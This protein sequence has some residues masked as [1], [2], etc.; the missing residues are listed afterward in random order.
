MPPTPVT[1]RSWFA[2]L[3]VVVA[4]LGALIA[5]V[6]PARTAHATDDGGF[7]A[8]M[9]EL[10]NQ[11]RA[12][13][14]VAPLQASESLR[15]AAQ[16]GRYDGCGFPVMGRADDMGARNYFSHTILGCG[17]QGLSSV[18]GAL[19]IQTSGFGE[20][21]AWMNGTTD[22]I[23]AATRLTNDLMA[24]PGHKA[25]ILNANFT[26]AGI[27]SWRTAAGKTWSGGGY[28][29]T[30]VFVGVQVFGR[31]STSTTTTPPAV[32]NVPTSLAVAGGDGVVNVSWA[33]AASGPAVDAYGAFVWDANGYTGRYAIVGP[34]GRA[35]TVTGVPNGRPYYVTLQGH[36]S[37]GWGATA[38]SSWVTV[39]A[40]PGPPTVVR[41]VPGNGSVT[42]TWKAPANTGTAIDGYGMFI[43]DDAGAYTGKYAWVCAACT[44]ATVPG[45][46][47]GRPY[48]AFIY[49]HNPNGWGAPVASDKVVAG[50]PGPPG[51]VTVARGS[52]SANVTWTPAANS[53][54]PID[55]YG[56]FVFDANGY[57]GIAAT[58][59]G[60][61]TSGTV[62]GLPSGS[63]TIAVFA[64]NAFGWGVHTMSAPV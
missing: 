30:N 22:P 33:P 8:K 31:M 52:G 59:C 23:V 4:L 57:T 61:C 50:T 40:V 36:N 54:Y 19:G 14:G 26:H 43:F 7:G 35:A 41:A 15:S 48:Y 46:V 25:N 55:M 18:L 60:T 62:S 12:G 13:A 51:T 42:A 39:A 49:A 5:T 56:M 9:L 47:N 3:A 20:N 34:T 24:S 17:T 27:G 16:D 28:A 38:T 2:R 1:S 10:V 32:P 53:G 58:A 63:Y 64:H 45:L 21:I 11:H 6:A 44:T 29:L 37:A